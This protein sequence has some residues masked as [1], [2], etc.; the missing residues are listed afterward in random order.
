MVKVPYVDLSQQYLE[1]RQSY[2]KIFD[3]VCKSGSF[4]GGAFI[5]KLENKISKILDTKYCLTLNSGTDSLVLSLYA[6]GIRKNDEVITV[7][8]SFI[9]T[10]SAIMHIGAKPI[11]VDVNEDQNIDVSKIEAKI[12]KKTKLILPVHLTGRVSNMSD[13]MKIA[14]K[15]KLHVIEDAAQS[16]L[17]KVDD[18]YAGTFG[19]IGCFSLHP[20]KNFNA[21]GDS[22]FIVTN[23]RKIYEKIKLLRNHG[24]NEKN[25]LKEFG[26]VSRMDNIQAALVLQNFKRINNIIKIRRRNANF[27]CKYLTKKIL[28][29]YEKLNQYNTYHTF[30]IQVKDRLK[31]QKYLLTKGIETKIHYPYLINYMK[32]FTKN[33]FNKDTPNAL[34]QKDR[35]LSLPIHQYLSQKQLQ[36]TVKIINSYY[37]S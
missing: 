17:S 5:K 34:F 16:F 3:S 36:Y 14:N 26:Y 22:G 28:I 29:N 8:N 11:F 19:N 9:A 15:Y 18:K 13:V 2:I 12:T 10:V 27:F 23:N 1:D 33:N 25:D 6:L 32:T 4:V 21:F 24:L 31:L 30:V 35:I 20:L 37:D 7:P